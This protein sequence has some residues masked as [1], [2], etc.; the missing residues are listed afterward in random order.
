[1]I[2]QQIFTLIGMIFTTA[3]GLY[4]LILIALFVW[5]GLTNYWCAFVLRRKRFK[6]IKRIKNQLK[7]AL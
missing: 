4:I 5:N 7:T 6:N 1:M 3:L 2:W